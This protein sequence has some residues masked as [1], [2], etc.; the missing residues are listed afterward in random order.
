MNQQVGPERDCHYCHLKVAESREVELWDG[1]VYCEAC[2]ESVCPGLSEYA[3][4]HSCLEE[5]VPTSGPTVFRRSLVILQENL[6]RL[7]RKAR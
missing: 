3:R 5:V 7:P 2:V 6:R 1:H 4:G